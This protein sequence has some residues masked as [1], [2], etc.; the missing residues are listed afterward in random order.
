MQ[1]WIFAEK[2]IAGRR[3]RGALVGRPIDVRSERA[4]TT[5]S[6]SSSYCALR[7]VAGSDGLSACNPYNTMWQAS[8]AKNAT[9]SAAAPSVVVNPRTA[10]RISSPA[11]VRGLL[12]EARATA[13]GPSQKGNIEKGVR[14]KR[15]RGAGKEQRRNQK[16]RWRAGGREERRVCDEGSKVAGESGRRRHGS[17]PGMQSQASSDDITLQRRRRLPGWVG[18]PKRVCE[19]SNEVIFRFKVKVKC[20]PRHIADAPSLLPS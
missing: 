16:A 7:K 3:V 19:W 2:P 1:L 10:P 15:N 8:A 18:K 4:L 20:I 9:P 13:I 17:Y 14:A 5:T 6:T 11:V 12:Q